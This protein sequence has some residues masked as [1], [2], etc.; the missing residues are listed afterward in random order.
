MQWLLW[1]LHDLW[2]AD[3]FTHIL[4]IYAKKCNQFWY[5][6]IDFVVNT[7][8]AINL[9]EEENKCP[10]EIMLD[11]RKLGCFFTKS[12]NA[13][14][15][16]PC[17][18]SLLVILDSLLLTQ[19]T[20]GIWNRKNWNVNM[21]WCTIEKYCDASILNWGFILLMHPYHSSFPC[22]YN[23]YFFSF[24]LMFIFISIKAIE[25]QWISES[26]CLFVP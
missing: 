12:W 3:N 17:D 2:S 19:M 5:Q 1:K 16:L 22:S 23:Q 6:N 4:S 10:F 21:K 15:N 7:Y 25:C 14:L 8:S 11:S 13:C 18:I 24:N 9:E 26:V 20:Q